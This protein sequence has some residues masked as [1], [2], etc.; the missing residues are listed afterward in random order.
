VVYVVFPQFLQTV[1]RVQYGATEAR[2]DPIASGPGTQGYCEVS[3]DAKGKERIISMF[4]LEIFRLIFASLVGIVFVAFVIYG[5]LQSWCVLQ[6]PPTVNLLLLIVSL[7][8][9]AYVE[10]LHYACVSIAKLD[11]SSYRHDYS[12]AYDCAVLLDTPT[13]VSILLSTVYA[14]L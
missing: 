6:L 14:Q 13:K 4:D 2:H 5:I 11:M 3:V 8:L 10:G 1:E 7:I 12:T 9:L